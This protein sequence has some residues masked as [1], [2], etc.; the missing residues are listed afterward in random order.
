MKKTMKKWWLVPAVLAMGTAQVMMSCEE[1][2]KEVIKEM[3]VPGLGISQFTV[4]ANGGES[5]LKISPSADWKA[6]SKTSWLKVSPASG[7]KA[8]KEIKLIA[9]PNEGF[10]NRPATLELTVGDSVL[11]N[12]IIQEGMQ[13]N[14]SIYSGKITFAQDAKEFTVSPIISNVEV[15]ALAWPSWI[16]SVDVREVPEGYYTAS[17]T[18]KD[19]DL[20]TETR[21][22]SVTFGDDAGYVRKFP[23]E[24][25][26]LVNKI[27]VDVPD[28]SG[29]FDHNTHSID[30]TV[31]NAT[32]EKYRIMFFKYLDDGAGMPEDKVSTWFSEVKPKMTSQSAVEGVK[33]T[34]QLKTFDEPGAPIRQ[35]A[36]CVVPESKVPEYTGGA[37]GKEYYLITQKN[38]F[39]MPEITREGNISAD[40]KTPAVYTVKV[41]KSTGIEVRAMYTRGGFYDWEVSPTHNIDAD[42]SMYLRSPVVIGE[43]EVVTKDEYTT[44]TYR[45]TSQSPNRQPSVTPMGYFV[46]FVKVDEGGYLTHNIE[47]GEELYPAYT[48]VRE[49]IS[50]DGFQL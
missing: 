36:F 25:E 10:E 47:W 40:G 24:C 33:H 17:I 37:V 39:E 7:T 18:L 15:K 14:I 2:E 8:D 4:S 44:Y 9:E 38:S 1:K 16:K 32:G 21:K 23:I 48:I 29:S 27:V 19:Y 3:L 35:V 13:K 20:D 22:D 49:E 12:T 43:P 42:F 28:L 50:I 5:I 46:V 41:K 34:I 31:Y 30:F 6:V 45:L 11:V 26:A